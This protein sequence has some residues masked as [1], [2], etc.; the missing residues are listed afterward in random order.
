MPNTK[1]AERRARNSV[2]RQSHN[3]SIKSRLRTTEGKFRALT[4]S[5]KKEDATASYRS[6]SSAFDKAAK[7]GVIPK[8]RANR[9]KSR[10]AAALAKS[11]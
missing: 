5:G 9:M 7:T 6:L 4:T 11:H 2:R 3:V 1:S 8:R 10:L